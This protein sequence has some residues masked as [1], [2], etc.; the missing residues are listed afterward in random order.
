MSAIV[1]AL[2]RSGKP[3]E[4]G[5]GERML[6]SLSGRPAD[7]EAHVQRD[8]WLLGARSFWVTPEAEG[9]PAVYVDRARKVT[10]VAD[11]RLDY[12]TQLCDAIGGSLGGGALRDEV[13]IAAAYARWGDACVER[14]E[15]DFTF[16][17][18]DAR[19]ERLLLAR[20]VYGVRA[21]YYAEVGGR[22]LFASQARALFADKAL[23]RR[24]DNLR[25]AEYLARVFADPARTFYRGVHR[26]PPAHV[27]VAS[28][29]GVSLRRYFRFDASRQLALGST[30]E[31]TEA[32]RATFAAAVRTRTRA[33]GPVGCLLSGGLDSAGVL[34]L[35]REQQ[36]GVDVPCFSALF[37]DFPEID[38]APW[39][40]L[41]RQRGQLALHTLRADTIGPLDD[42]D[43]LHEG[44]DEPF[45]APNLFIYAALAR[46][47]AGQGVRVLLDGLDGDSVV[48][49]GWLFLS[50]LLLGGR[51]RRLGR[52]L[53][54]LHRRGGLP[55]AML[56]QTW[57]LSPAL[58]RLRLGGYALRPRSA[59]RG[60]L[61]A[62]FARS[63]DFFV[64][65][66]ARA[67]DGLGQSL[68]FRAQHA[69][70]IQAPL[71]PFYLEVH[72]KLA[73]A[74]GV[75]HRHPFF[76][77]RVIELC[78]S[79]PPEQRLHDG[80]D[81]VI[82]RRAFQDLVPAPICARVSKSV[83][84]ANFRRQL[85]SH[86]AGRIQALLALSPSPLDG[87]VDLRRLRRD[88]ARLGQGLATEEVLDFWTAVTLGTWLERN[89]VTC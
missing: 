51:V 48:E 28:R 29:A 69:R 55:Y 49:H 81:R 45:H 71:M 19:G 25:V 21:L 36:P 77:R 66:A 86:N 68:R 74:V 4:P 15:G 76:D 53:R 26:L 67:R 20:D 38:E 80:W 61:D 11:V 89:S 43:A 56:V 35:L 41:H 31:Y 14:L 33:S 13:L 60:Y 7:S 3:L 73:A 22:L 34:G 50:E 78:L 32:F 42:I 12:R 87:L 40:A 30:A 64:H 63:T 52:E 79:L 2:S 62:D 58:E 8:T 27:L 10:V 5:L 54:A 47:A 44:L 57:A 37:P 85:F 65:A 24:A 9:Q 46:L 59:P 6:A 18:W 75:D 83:W 70:A 1:G 23:V 17:L 39:L 88:A 84:S 16:A 82:E 72:D